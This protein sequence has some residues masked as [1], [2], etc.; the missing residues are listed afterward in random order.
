M[1]IPDTRP[2]TMHIKDAMQT[3]TYTLAEP[4]GKNFDERFKPDLSPKQ[5]LELGVFGGKYMTDGRDEFPDDWF[6]NAKLSATHDKSLNYFGVDAS[7]P[8]KEW[9]RK[10]WIH[11]MDPRG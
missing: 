2:H 10:G 9:I 1:R 7:Q 5:M 11:P 3:A 6:T 8:L 4:M